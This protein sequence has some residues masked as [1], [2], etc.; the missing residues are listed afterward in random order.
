MAAGGSLG[1]G[2][3]ERI[4]GVVVAA[5]TPEEEAAGSPGEVAG[6]APV[7]TPEGEAAERSLGVGLA[8]GNPG[9]E[10]VGSLVEGPA[11][12]TPG[13]GNLVV[14]AD[15]RIW[16]WA[17]DKEAGTWLSLEECVVAEDP[18]VRRKGDDERK[19]KIITKM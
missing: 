14:G 2:P 4:L 7:R 15:R 17:A 3:A 11:G 12:R 9:G 13:V 6:K 10:A 8:E 1:E 19:I 16:R 18:K 5:G